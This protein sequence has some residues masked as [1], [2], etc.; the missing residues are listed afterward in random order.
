MNK[1]NCGQVRGLFVTGT[2][3]GVGKTVVTAAITAML[4]AEGLNAGVWKPIQSGAPLGSGLTDAERLLKST[5]INERPEAVAP[6]TFEAPLTPMLAAKQAG[7]TLTLNEIIA[8]GLPLTRRYEVL[9]IEGAGGVAVPLTEDA[10]MVDFISE[11]GIPALIVARSGLG[12]I[13]HTL[14]TASFLQN[15]GV[16]IVGVVLNEGELTE[17]ND[18]PSVT[19]NA[20]LI[21]QYSNLKVLGR[22]PHLYAEATSETLIH[23]VRNTIQFTP[24]REAF[25]VQY[26][27][28]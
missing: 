13:N 27:G 3:T 8:S 26:M 19:T 1:V 25:A 14:L 12:T 17:L 20:Q 5:E 2:D 4:R 11:L 16:P 18:D 24:I 7:V 6:F 28:G 21:E 9:L 22:F 15:R 23:T 10:L